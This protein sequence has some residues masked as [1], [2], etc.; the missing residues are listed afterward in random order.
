MLLT[1]STETPSST[2]CVAS[3]LLGGGTTEGAVPTDGKRAFHTSSPSM[4]LPTDN[5][6]KVSTRLRTYDTTD[7]CSLARDVADG[8]TQ[9]GERVICGT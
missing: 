1:C 6:R 8:K 5:V 2:A 9:D 4:H 3:P 7:N